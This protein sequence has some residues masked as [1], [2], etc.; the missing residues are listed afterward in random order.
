MR[1]RCG[2]GA[3]FKVYITPDFKKRGV[4]TEAQGCGGDPFPDGCV[5]PI[6]N[7]RA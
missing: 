1:R 4:G 7:E 2:G 6:F 5:K 3:A